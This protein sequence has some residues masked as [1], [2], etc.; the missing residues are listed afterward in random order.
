VSRLI[1][2][3]P[4]YPPHFLTVLPRN[5][6]ERETSTATRAGIT[7]NQNKTRERLRS[8]SPEMASPHALAAA[9]AAAGRRDGTFWRVVTP[10]YGARLQPREVIRLEVE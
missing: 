7:T 1:P 6:F 9:A 5:Y 4:D 3:L 2:L 10:D 8:L